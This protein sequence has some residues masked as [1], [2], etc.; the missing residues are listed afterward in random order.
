M[1]YQKT[2]S[3]NYF[4]GITNEDGKILKELLEITSEDLDITYIHRASSF[5][6]GRRVLIG[7][8][9]L[10]CT[11]EFLECDD[12]K[13]V[14]LVF[15]EQLKNIP[16]LYFIFTEPIIN[17]GGE[18]IFW[19]TFD[20]AMNIWNFV[21]ELRLKGDKYYI[22]NAKGLSNYFYDLYDK[23]KGTYSL[24]KVLRFGPI[25]QVFNGGEALSIGGFLNYGLRKGIYQSLS[26]DNVTQ[27]TN[28]EGYDE[29]TAISPDSKVACVMTTRYSEHTSLE[30]IGLIPTPYSILASYLFSVD[31]LN[32][33]IFN[34]R[35]DKPTNGNLG[36][37]LVDLKRMKEDKNYKGAM[38]KTEDLWIFNGFM[39][40]SPDSKK[41][42]F[43]E[44]KKGTNLRRC[45]VV[46][47]KNYKPDKIDFK[48]NFNGNVPYARSIEET[49]NLHLDFPI[50]INVNGTSGDLEIFHNDTKCELTYNEFSEDN[51]TFYNGTYYYEKFPDEHY[52]I[53]Q[54]DIQSEGKKKGYCK[55]RLWFDLTEE[56]FLFDKANDGNNKSYGNCKYEGKEIKVDIYQ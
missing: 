21:G 38:L 13:L 44:I 15:P 51:E 11:K 9:I 36:P 39:S 18:H 3:E 49:L 22:E 37:V 33:I 48:N 46:K 34:L 42:M 32:F 6:D 24:P 41:V 26:E 4:A 7:G 50:N 2:N 30:I 12:A 25:K 28:F 47:L 40:W 8:K 14:D 5:S 56:V 43:D 19:S 27:L 31:A 17:Y 55:Y 10:E 53:F 52:V 16:N 29:T 1:V 23:E 35:K 20:K 45:Q 54:V